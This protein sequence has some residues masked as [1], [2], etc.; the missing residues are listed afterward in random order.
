MVVSL[1]NFEDVK[2]LMVSLLK[3]LLHYFLAKFSHDYRATV[4][5]LINQLGTSL[6]VNTSN[7]PGQKNTVI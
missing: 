3:F 7:I 4:K 5:E 2:D 1:T 6:E